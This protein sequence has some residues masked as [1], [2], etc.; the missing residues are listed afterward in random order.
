MMRRRTTSFNSKRRIQE[1]ADS[2]FLEELVN[3]VR[4]GGNPEHKRNP[5]D[6][7]LTP[8]ALPR[9]DKSLC[10]SAEIFT[11]AEAERLLRAGIERGLISEQMRNGY[12]QNIWSVKGNMP[13]EAQLENGSQG[14]YHGYP[15]PCADPF[16]KEILE[17]WRRHE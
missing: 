17:R 15:V 7:G 5:G 14:I 6:F 16:G 12:P 2:N 9:P 13:L 10:D 1:N 8:P 3:S 4:Y 11:R